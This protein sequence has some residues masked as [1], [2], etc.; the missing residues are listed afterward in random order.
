MLGCG[1]GST[2]LQEL[3]KRRLVASGVSLSK[4]N[5]TPEASKEPQRSEQMTF[6]RVIRLF[7]SPVT[8]VRQLRDTRQSVRVVVSR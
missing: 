3:R 4:L 6:Q 5:N 1:P 7:V 2:L 8:D